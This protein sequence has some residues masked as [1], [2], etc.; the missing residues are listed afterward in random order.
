M[1]LLLYKLNKS[2]EKESLFYTNIKFCVFSSVNYYQYH[3]STL[4]NK[5]AYKSN[6]YKQDFKTFVH[7]SLMSNI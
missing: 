6:Y 2:K 3:H 5:S 1:Y 7:G 4:G